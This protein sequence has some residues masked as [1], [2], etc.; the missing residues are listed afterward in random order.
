M[1]V[2]LDWLVHLGYSPGKR[3]ELLESGLRDVLRLALYAARSLADPG[4]PAI[5][6]PPPEDRRFSDPA[7]HRWP[8]NLTNNPSC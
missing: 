1:L 2:Y 7:W 6:E 3:L 5:V 4:T 8:F